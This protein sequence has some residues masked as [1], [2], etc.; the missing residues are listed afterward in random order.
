MLLPTDF[1]LVIPFIGV[2]CR[3]E[4][5]SGEWRGG[6]W[7]RIWNLPGMGHLRYRQH[8]RDLDGCTKLHRSDSESFSRIFRSGLAS[9]HPLL[10]C[11]A[12]VRGATWQIST[13]SFP[14]LAP[15]CNGSPNPG[16]R[17]DSCRNHGQRGCV[18]P[19]P[20]GTTISF[21]SEHH[22]HSGN[23]RRLDRRLRRYSGPYPIRHQTNSGL[24]NHKPTWIYGSGVRCR[25]LRCRTLS[26]SHP[27]RYEEFPVSLRRKRP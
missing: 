10:D 27:W 15:I 7:P 6:C 2:Q 20:H 22:D 8:S 1:A 12:I 18:P 4:S 13:N 23:R 21:G 25:R 9:P 16:L 17:T 11:V 14:C 5:L 19:D 3:N 26:P 24:L